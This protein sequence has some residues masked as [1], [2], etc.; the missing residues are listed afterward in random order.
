MNLQTIR[1]RLISAAHRWDRWWLRDGPPHAIAV[2]RMALGIQLLVAFGMKLPFASALLSRDGLVLPIDAPWLPSAIH[3]ILVPPSPAIATAL[4]IIFL[5][6]ALAMTMGLWMRPAILLL[7]ALYGWMY[8]ID[9]HLFWVTYERLMVLALTIL[10]CSGA[11]RAFSVRM[12][13]R[14]GSWGAWEPACVLPQR[15]LALQITATYLGV[16]WQ[17][18]WLPTWRDGDVLAASFAG[19]WG[20]PLAFA[21]ARFH[22]SYRAFD[23]MNILVKVFEVTLPFGLWM[24]SIRKWFFLGGAVFHLSIALLL[25]IWQ[26]LVL[27]PLYVLFLEPEEAKDVLEGMARKSKLAMTSTSKACAVRVLRKDTR[28]ARRPAR[29]NPA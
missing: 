20:T 12:R 10:L 11:D 14:H 24:P 15:L 22:L 4:L 21:L 7:L 19:R 3:W 13:L 1:H 2:A 28:H 26:F 8:A 25:Q 23:A 5:L 27:V 18:M 6:A 17:K 29:R 9:L 16:G